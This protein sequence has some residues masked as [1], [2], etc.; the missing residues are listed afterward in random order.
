MFHDAS[1]DGDDDGGAATKIWWGNFCLATTITN[2]PARN[3]HQKERQK[4]D[5]KANWET[6]I[7]NVKLG[8]LEL[9]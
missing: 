7:E 9:M 4:I 3:Y 6:K 5:M 2:Q 8:E 1:G